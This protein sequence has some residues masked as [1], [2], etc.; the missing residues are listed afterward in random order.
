MRKKKKIKDD[1]WFDRIKDIKNKHDSATVSVIDTKTLN[2]R[3]LVL[4]CIRIT[5]NVQVKRVDTKHPVL[6][7]RVIPTD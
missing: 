6:L 5:T 2:R 7:E 3:F 4:L 1:S